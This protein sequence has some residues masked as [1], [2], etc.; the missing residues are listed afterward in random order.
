MEMLGSEWRLKI[1]PNGNGFV[2][3]KYLSIYLMMVSKSVKNKELK[4]KD[5]TIY[6]YF[7]EI[8]R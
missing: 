7:I 5:P 4:T 6:E 1:H 2:E 8:V 3:G